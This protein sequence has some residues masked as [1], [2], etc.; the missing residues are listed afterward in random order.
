MDGSE[1][2]A[3]A[4]IFTVGDRA[5]DG[6]GIRET[7]LKD[8]THVHFI[9]TELLKRLDD[10]LTATREPF[11]SDQQLTSAV[12]RAGLVSSLDHSRLALELDAG[13]A[14]GLVS[15]YLSAADTG[16][17]PSDISRR[18]LNRDARS[19]VAEAAHV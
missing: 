19:G 5:R 7:H 13:S 16:A 9:P 18:I 3:F 10:Q 15:E 2:S 6:L 11:W 4:E 8:G 1:L 17:R 14:V 12:V